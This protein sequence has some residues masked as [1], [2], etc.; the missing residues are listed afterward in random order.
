[1]AY[2][3]T[4]FETVILL[5]RILDLVLL[6]NDFLLPSVMNLHPSFFICE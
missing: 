6:S 5:Q 3:T 2:D 1:M 4:V